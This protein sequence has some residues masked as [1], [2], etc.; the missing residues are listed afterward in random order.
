MTRPSALA[1][2]VMP[3]FNQAHYL[4]TAIES[5]R[6]QSWPAVEAVVVD[7]GSTD[8]TAD[9]ARRMGATLVR[10]HNQGLAS[11]RNAGLAAARG[12]YIVFLDAD[13]ELL[14]HAV[15]SGIDALGRHPDAGAVAR[16]A[17]LMD[18]RGRPLPTNHPVLTS[19]D[20]YYELL[21]TNFVWTPGAA[22][23][24]REAV[25]AVGGFPVAEPATA[26]YALLLALARRGLLVVEP[27][28]V[29]R[30]RKH[31]CNMSRDPMLML[32]AALA[33]LNRE[34]RHLPRAY[35]PAWL[36][37]RRRWQAFYGEQLV[38]DLRREWHGPRRFSILARGALFL[39]HR[40]PAHAAIHARRKLA[41]VVAGAP[42]PKLPA[43]TD[44]QAS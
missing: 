41:R 2:V 25:R 4:A 15:R 1:T 23:F 29:V 14:P 39:C 40:C 9:V 35:R 11:A 7:D 26:D 6:G 10:Q 30:Y 28:E 5:V 19:A 34:R 13:D 22:L 32:R 44:I 33:T 21:L 3:C 27:L 17:R 36:E 38:A 31:E 8:D 12:D 42:R 20:L 16:R 18:A 37:G 43:D 24:R